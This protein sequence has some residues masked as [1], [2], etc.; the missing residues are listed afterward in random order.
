MSETSCAYVGFV[1]PDTPEYRVLGFGRAGNLAQNGFVEAI[2][3][4]GLGLDYI[5]SFQPIAAW[6]KSSVLFRRSRHIPLH[7]NQKIILLPL[8][9]LCGLREI[10]RLVCLTYEMIKW[11]VKTCKKKRVVF[12]Y[13][14]FFPQAIIMRLLTWVLGVKYVPIIY[15]WGVMGGGKTSLCEMRGLAKWCLP[16]TDGRIVIT[17]A[18]ANSCARGKHYLRIDGGITHT[19]EELLFPLIPNEKDRPFVLMFA[20]SVSEWNNIRQ[21]LDFISD[22]ADAG[23]RLWIAGDG[24]LVSLVQKVAKGDSRVSYIGML[25]HD[26]LFQKYAK[27]DLLL[28]LRNVDA[29]AGAYHYPSS[30]LEMLVT[31][32]PVITT[33]INHTKKEY[34]S[35]C[36]VIDSI[37]ELDMAV[38]KFRN[39]SE[40]ERLSYGR[41]ARKWMLENKLWQKQGTNIQKYVERYVLQRE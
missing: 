1:V 41:K 30:L 16:R 33:A 34:G 18:I 6:P 22:S 36:Q 7:F 12:V 15:D 14:L 5:W 21:L 9:N 24:P 32:K 38:A 2:A 20:G 29:V 23:L 3:A 35:I 31:G 8:I 37:D 40:Q 10:V 39:M 4:S 11:S 17:D 19:V 28:N 26:A 13:N 27:C 25:D